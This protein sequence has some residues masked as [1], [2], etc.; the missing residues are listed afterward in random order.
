MRAEIA[1]MLV[2]RVRADAEA[3]SAR[4]DR[5][6]TDHRAADL[7]S[8]DGGVAGLDQRAGE[9]AAAVSATGQANAQQRDRQEEAG[10][11]VGESASRLAG[12]ATLELLLAGWAA[13]TAHAG[14]AIS[15]VSEDGAAK[16]R[17]LN[18]DAVRFMG[19]LV[20]AR[21]LVGE[22][23]SAHPLQAGRLAGDADAIEA[24]GTRTEDT[25]SGVTG[26]RQQVEALRDQNTRDAA[27]AA[28][29]E[30][31]AA[32]DA[33]T[34]GEAAE[35]TQARH[36]QLAA[37]LAA[38]AQRHRE[39]RRAAVAGTC[40]RLTGQGYEVIHASDW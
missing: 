20:R 36:D 18:A 40:E 25:R 11:A 8:V 19:Q 30:R 10:V 24:E 13:V 35:Q 27:G 28:E 21:M 16:M 12:L 38:W 26:A 32:R 5:A 29:A 7:S 31:R 39:Q 3:A 22:Q 33:A 9:Q 37:E 1:D 2:C 17:R 4:A 14:A 23:Q 15:L 34:A 6:T